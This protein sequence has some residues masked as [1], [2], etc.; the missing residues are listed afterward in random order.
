MSEKIEHKKLSEQRSGSDYCEFMSRFAP[1]LGQID[2]PDPF[3]VSHT[4]Q[5]LTKSIYDV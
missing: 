1:F 4:D 5:T 3:Y 2:G